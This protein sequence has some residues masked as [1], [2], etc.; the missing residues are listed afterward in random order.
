MAKVAGAQNF[1]GRNWYEQHIAMRT[2]AALDEQDR[3]GALPGPEEEGS[4]KGAER[5]D[6]EPDPQQPA[7]APLPGGCG[8]L[9]GGAG[10]AAGG[11]G[12]GRSGHGWRLPL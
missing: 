3:L 9:H 10:L 2:R 6:Q 7:G 12:R 1:D 5:D 8:V 4:E 11:C